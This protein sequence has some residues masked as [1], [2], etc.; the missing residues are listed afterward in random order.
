MFDVTS[1]EKEAHFP[2]RFYP[3]AGK[4]TMNQMDVW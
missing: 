3:H 2:N 4:T 1:N